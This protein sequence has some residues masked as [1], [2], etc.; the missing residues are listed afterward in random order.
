MNR[1][2]TFERVAEELNRGGFSYSVAHGIDGYPG[3]VGRDLDLVLPRA[4][5]DSA[6]D[7]ARAAMEESGL[8]VVEPPRIWGRRLVAAHPSGRGGMVEIHMLPELRWRNVRIGGPSAAEQLTG[9]FPVDPWI[10]WSKRVLIPVLCGDGGRIRGRSQ[11]MRFRPLELEQAH[12]RLPLLVGS[13]L[14][15][16]L[17]EQL[18]GDDPDSVLA[19]APACRRAAV[20]RAFLTRPVYSL[21][22]PVR[23]LLRRVRL[24]FSASAPVIAIVGPDGTGKSTIVRELAKTDDWIFLEIIGRHWRPGVLPQLGTFIG[25]RGP[26]PGEAR[27]PRRTAGRFAGLR[28]TYYALDV[29]VGSL[30]SDRSAAGRQKLVV[31]DRCFLDMVVD[32]LR[33]GLPTGNGVRLIWSLLPKPDRIVALVGDPVAI[34]RRKPELPIADV[35]EQL[36]TWRGLAAAGLVS[37]SVNVDRPIDDV[38]ESVRKLVVRAFLERNGYAGEPQCGA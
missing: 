2:S 29:L 28:L 33:Y 17:L 36:A 27:P 26:P 23:A 24:P 37:D 21:T 3:S 16:R 19:L 12:A 30:L 5:I 10:S 32:P 35:G 20:R 13:E 31:Y 38:V 34:H 4:Q 6:I 25:R 11:E 18:E 14:S 15:G 9:P 8:A 7:A 1:V 22:W